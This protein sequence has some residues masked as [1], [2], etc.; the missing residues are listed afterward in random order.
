[1]E[2][3]TQDILGE[4]RSSQERGV[5]DSIFFLYVATPGKPPS[6]LHSKVIAPYLKLRGWKKVSYK[7]TGFRYVNLTLR[8]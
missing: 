8:Q 7:N 1:M 2:L 6:A 4:I 3:D 5:E